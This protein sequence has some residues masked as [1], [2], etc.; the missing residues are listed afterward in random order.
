M[1]SN[2]GFREMGEELVDWAIA[3]QSTVFR[4]E[5]SDETIRSLVGR[6]V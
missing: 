3:V 2:D 4:V 1:V 5:D 6:F